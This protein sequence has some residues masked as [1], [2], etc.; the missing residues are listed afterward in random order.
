MKQVARSLIIIMSL[1][2]LIRSASVEL[3]LAKYN[4]RPS[5]RPELVADQQTNQNIYRRLM[6]AETAPAGAAAAPAPAIKQTNKQWP[7]PAGQPASHSIL[8][9]PNL[10]RPLRHNSVCS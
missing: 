2:R 1:I 3:L 5:R 8:F 9:R 7:L 4:K 6:I 10:V